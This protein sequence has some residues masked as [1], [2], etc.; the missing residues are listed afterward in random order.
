[1]VQPACTQPDADPVMHEHLQAIGTAVGEQVGVMWMR[2]AEHLHDTTER[3]IGA[4]S[5]VQRFHSQ[6]YRVDAD[7]ARLTAVPREPTLHKMQRRPS[8][9]SP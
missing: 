1:M 6:P 9:K 3:R 7:H 4:G 2:G 8:A 5:H